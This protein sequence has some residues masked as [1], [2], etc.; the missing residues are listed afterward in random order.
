[1]IGS[2]GR[3]AVQHAADVDVD[4]PVPLV[5][6]E[7]R[8]AATAASAGIVDDDVDAAELGLGVA[9]ESLDIA[10]AR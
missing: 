9:D 3:D 1:M 6:L 7:R 10:R 4:H 2:A 5:D 8:R